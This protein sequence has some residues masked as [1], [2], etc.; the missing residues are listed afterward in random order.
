MFK[1]MDDN[2]DKKLDKYEFGKGFREFGCELTKEEV[3]ELFTIF[4]RNG[5]GFVDFEDM[6]CTLRQPMRQC[7]KDLITISDLR[8]VYTAKYH[9]K[10][11]SGKMTEDEVFAEFLQTFTQSTKPVKEVKW[12]EFFNY[13]HGIS[14]SIDLDVYFDVMMRQAWKL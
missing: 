10:F 9:P 12:E 3:A 7:R 1:I 11:I 13:Y 8:G 14:C 5:S 4:D 6:L 2:G